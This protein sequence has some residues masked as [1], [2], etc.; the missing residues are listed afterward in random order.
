MSSK[1]QRISR[2]VWLFAPLAAV[3]LWVPASHGQGRG[4]RGNAGMQT[5]PRD[6][7][8]DMQMKITEPFTLA[9]VGDIDAHCRMAANLTGPTLSKQR[10]KVDRGLRRWIREFRID[11]SRRD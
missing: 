1:T 4:G 10:L 9:S 7:T 3:L 6:W 8:E 2:T 5:P 11:D